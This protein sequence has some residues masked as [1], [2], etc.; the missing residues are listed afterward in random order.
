[1]RGVEI[2]RGPGPGWFRVALAVCASLYFVLLMHHP[3]AQAG[4]KQLSY[5]AECTCLF[6]SADVYATEYRLDAWSCADRDWR[7][8][9]PRAYFQ[10]H[11]D[12][13]ESRFQRISYFYQHNT[14]VMR[15]LS[16]FVLANHDTRSDG[17]TGKIGGIRISKLERPLP[18]PGD[19]VER[20]HYDPLGPVPL[21]AIVKEVY[22]TPG[23]KRAHRCDQ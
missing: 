15:A 5:F 3:K 2:A 23:N 7:P 22:A 4:M 18:V 12:D 6:P 20:Y 14:Y 9:D 10:I 1:M 16:E 11:A 17:F 21:N 13:K 19:T 8:L